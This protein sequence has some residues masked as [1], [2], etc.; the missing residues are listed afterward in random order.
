MEMKVHCALTERE[1][2]FVRCVGWRYKKRNDLPQF[3][4]SS[5]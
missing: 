5:G 2:D 1:P 3:D 4:V